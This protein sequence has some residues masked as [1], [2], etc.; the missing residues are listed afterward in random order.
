[1]GQALRPDVGIVSGLAV[2]ARG[3]ILHSGLWATAEGSLVDAFSGLPL[4]SVSKKPHCRSAHQVEAVG[5]H[6][7]AI[8]RELL[9]A[10]GGMPLIRTD[11]MESLA[12]KA[13]EYARSASLKVIVT[14]Y[15]IA[16]CNCLEPFV[17][18]NSELVSWR[19]SIFI[20]PNL[21]SYRQV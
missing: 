4:T 1:M 20:N 7:F 11:G 6:F 18:L 19:K 2:D 17:P 21:I 3:N 10:L 9:V 13:V 8:R 15:A 14:P 16:S 12:L 5:E